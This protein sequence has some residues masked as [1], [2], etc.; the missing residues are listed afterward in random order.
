MTVFALI[1]GWKN[2]LQTI[3]TIIGGVG[4]IFGSILA[5]RYCFAFAPQITL[6]L[7][8]PMDA[9]QRIGVVT[10]KVTNTSKTRVRKKRLLL[11]ILFYNVDRMETLGEWVPF[12][13][14]YTSEWRAPR[15]ICTSTKYVYWGET[16]TVDHP[17]VF[18]DC[19]GG[20]YVAHIGLQFY[21]KLSLGQ[22]FLGNYW[23]KRK[24]RWTTTTYVWPGGRR[25]SQPIS[26][27]GDA[28]EAEI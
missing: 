12:E 19:P 10:I 17:I 13:N 11:Q 14:D 20:P 7:S 26:S 6:G 21:A 22:R 5:W 16:I 28:G 1:G 27:K 24:E 18:P 15:E 2:L 8:R 9:S 23:G 3:V 25:N 4:V